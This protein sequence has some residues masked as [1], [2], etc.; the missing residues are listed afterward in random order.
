V[1]Q[2]ESKPTN[3][4][5]R[6]SLGRY[7]IRMVILRLV[8]TLAMS[9]GLLSA[10][11]CIELA[12]KQARHGAEVVFRG[13]VA[14]YRDSG[15]DYRIVIFRVTR[16]WKGHI[17]QTF[18]MPAYQG[19]WCS[20]FRQT[21]PSLLTVGNDLLVYASRIDLAKEDY[22]PMPCNTDLVT[23]VRNFRDLGRGRKPN[24]KE[25]TTGF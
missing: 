2:F 23:K 17:G 18:E 1:S 7:R 25:P 13:T 16:V 8:F 5:R 11:D 3:G 22:F 14:G 20:A 24:S 21:K 10:C 12:P 19:D 9:A 6:N 15:R 4:V